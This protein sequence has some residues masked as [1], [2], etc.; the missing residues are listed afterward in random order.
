MN[1]T[2][3]NKSFIRVASIVLF[4][5]L[6]NLTRAQTLDQSC[7]SNGDAWNLN[8]GCN[9]GGWAG[10]LGQSF[11]AGATGNLHSIEL[12]TGSSNSAS[13]NYDFYV[14]SGN[15]V[16]GSLLYSVTGGALSTPSAASTNFTITLSSAVAIT[17]GQQYTFLLVYNSGSQTTIATN[18]SNSCYAGGTAYECS[19]GHSV[20]SASYLDLDFKTYVT[21]G[22]TLDQQNTSQANFNSVYFQTGGS[23]YTNLNG[24]SFTAGMSGTLSKIDLDIR[25]VQNSGGGYCVVEVYSGDGHGGSLLATSAPV[26]VNTSFQTYSFNLNCTVVSGQQYTWYMSSTTAGADIQNYASNSDVYA[27]GHAWTRDQDNSTAPTFADHSNSNDF[28]FKTYVGAASASS[29]ATLSAM[30]L[31]SGTLSPSFAS[32]TT[33][34]TASVT[35]ST[36]SI[37]VTPTRNEAH[38]TI[39]VR[40]NGGSYS[41]V[42]SGNASSALSLNFG[43]NTINVKV[44]A[45][46]G[47]TIVT[48]TTTVTRANYTAVSNGNWTSTSTWDGNEVPSS[49][50]DIIVDADLDINTNVTVHNLT[51]NSGRTLNHTNNTLSIQSGGTIACNGTG[52]FHST[53]VVDFL[54]SASKTGAGT[55]TFTYVYADAGNVDFGSS[56][57]IDGGYLRISQGASISNKP[58]YTNPIG[59]IYTGA[60]TITIGEEWPTGNANIAGVSIDAGTTLSFGSITSSRTAGTGN[61]DVFTI[62]GT[63]SLS[64]ASGGDLI[65]QHT[66]ANFNGTFNANGRKVTV[67]GGGNH[68]FQPNSNTNPIT[69][70]DLEVSG[71]P[72]C[73]FQFPVTITH[74]L[75]LTSGVMYIGNYD[76]TI[77]SGATLTGGSA[78]S[79]L[80]H[81]GSGKLVRK[82]IGNSATLFPLGI[83]WSSYTP[84]TITNGGNFDYAVRVLNTAPSGTGV[85]LPSKVL[86]RE[87]DITP[88]GAATNVD[89]TFQYNTGDGKTGGT[90][91]E[92]GSMNGIR[93]N[94]SSSSWSS[95]GTASA[96]GSN[97][98]TVSLTTPNFTNSNLYSV[99]NFYSSDATLSNMTLSVGTLSPSFASGTTSYTASVS[100][101]TS[102]ITVTPTHTNANA[103]IEARVNGGSYASVTSGSASSALSLNVGSNTID[104]RVTAE[105][106]TT[107]KTYTTTVCRVPTVSISST[108]GPLCYGDDASFTLTGTS[109][110]TV[111]YN[112]NGASNTT[113]VLTGGTSIITVTGATAN[114]TLN[115]VSI[116]DGTCSQSLSGNSTIIVNVLPS[117]T[118]NSNSVTSLTTQY[119]NGSTYYKG[120]AFQTDILNAINID[121]FDVNLR[122]GAGASRTVNVY[123]K[124]GGYSGFTS[125][126]S[127]WTLLGNY[128]VTSAG[129]NNATRIPLSSVLTL[130][131]GNYSFFFYENNEGVGFSASGS[132]GTISAQN[133]D[134]KIRVGTSIYHFFDNVLFASRNFN[135]TFYYSKSGV[136]NMT[137]TGGGSLCAGSPGQT[138]TLSGSEVG[139]NYQLVRNGSINVGS[140]KS[141]TG[142]AINWTSISTAGTYTV[143]ATNATTNCQVTLPTN[144]SIQYYAVP[145]ASISGS[146]TICQSLSSPNLTFTGSSGTA[147]YTFTYHINSGSDLTISTTSG[148]S[149][150]VSIPTDSAGTFKYYLTDVTDASVAACPA[151][152]YDSITAVILPKPLLVSNASPVTNTICEG[153]S[154]VITCTNAGSGVG[155]PSYT[156]LYSNNFNT[157]IGTGW[158]F[159]ATNPVTATPAI[160]SW[161]GASVLGNMGAQQAILNLTGIPSHD[162]I[163]VDFDLYIHDTW[164]GNNT[165]SGPDIFNM[166]VDGSSVVNTTFSNWSFN[167]YNEQA[168]PNNIPATNPN[169]TGAVATNLPTACNSAVSTLST[170]YH[171]TKTIA[172]TASSLTLLLEAVGIEVACNESWSIDNLVIQR[173]TPAPSS[174]ILWSTNQVASNITVSPIDTT[175]Y[176]ATLGT[177]TN[178]ITI[179]VNPT[180]RAN[181]S[182]DNAGQC[183]LTNNFNLTNTS[184]LAGPGGFTSAWTCTGSNTPTATSTDLTNLTY[185]TPGTKNTTLVVTSNYGN[186]SASSLSLASK[187]KQLDITDT[188]FVRASNSNPICLGSSVSLSATQN[189]VLSGQG[190]AVYTSYYT[191]NF[192]TSAD[193]ANWTFP[194]TV[195]VTGT[196]VVKSWG[197]RTVLGNMGA[198]QAILNLSGLP[199]HDK[200][201]VEF[202]LYIHDTWDGNNVESGPDIWNMKVDGSSVINTTFSNWWFTPYNTQAYPGNIPASNPNYTGSVETNLPTACNSQVSTLSTRYRI[203]KVVDH[204]A[205]SLALLLEAIGIEVACNESWSID[206]LSIQMGS[207]SGVVTNAGAVQWSNG[208]TSTNST[209]VVTPGLGNTTYTAAIGHCATDYTVTVVPV[210]TPAFTYSNSNCS[211][212]LSFTNTNIEASVSYAWN[213]G[214]ASAIYNGTTA[215]NHI[216]TNGTYTITLT[217]T[218]PSGCTRQT[219]RTVTIADQPTASFTSSTSTSCTNG[220]FFTSTSTI[221]SGNT[222]TYLWNFGDATTSTLENPTKTYASASSYNVSLTVTTGTTCTSTVSHSVN[223]PAGIA[224]AT[225][226]F[227]AAV[228]GT[229]GNKVTTTNLTTGTGNQYLWNFDDGST[230][231][232]FEPVH[233][234]LIGGSRTI[235]LTV[236]NAQGCTSSYNQQVSISANSGSTARIG[237]DFTIS[238]SDTQVLSTNKFN[239]A[240]VFT[241]MPNN[242]PP[243]YANGAPTWSFGDSTSSTNT[244]IYNKVYTATGNY[245][246]KIS[247]L[248]TNTG[249]YSEASRVV[250]VVPTPVYAAHQGINRDVNASVASATTGIEAASNTLAQFS[251]YPNPNNGNFKVMLNNVNVKNAEISIVDMLGREVYN[252]SYRL[253]GSSD[254]LEIT[255]LNVKS[256]SY[257]IIITSDGAV[258]GR[259]AFI[260]VAN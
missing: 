256:G 87:W 117:I 98:Y 186:C 141:G 76:L 89:L 71:V 94:T 77:N 217:A 211:K 216:Y 214:D 83:S 243:V 198:Q 25:A 42:T 91:S 199:A 6:V 208:S 49:G 38:A 136:V 156:G 220:V 35:S 197:G 139:V 47:S 132:T 85:V 149:V 17:S 212:T 184:S 142:N 95:F 45:E 224:A 237:V 177:C 160:K 230:S 206:S 164:D 187:T 181:F 118:Y 128:T 46:D 226:N 30:T 22:A 109:G 180:P 232:D 234:Y 18:N 129:I 202:D 96:S 146:T 75:K 189:G 245:T 204:S 108:N 183:I 246:V 125:S 12:K 190:P 3:Q 222:A 138:L 19:N 40:V 213:F 205:S 103:T 92:T 248:T 236:I 13:A 57:N 86:N 105:D 113:T 52:Y 158:T 104:V 143:V 100:N 135:G 145:S 185:S 203:S 24:Q 244:N 58:S 182:I 201:K 196:P 148:N 90:F 126:T 68:H 23:Q 209:I 242:N 215:P 93:Y 170:K 231:S 119:S 207:T 235:S 258:I 173:R 4:L 112:I 188:V 178:T 61:N 241:N 260:M 150:T 33:T 229:C 54:G 194:A 219:T 259:K 63:L 106:G 66:Y 257:N 88:S 101:S 55:A 39:Q 65:L 82:N 27:G 167:P 247:Q 200:I 14:Y 56:S 162:F 32:G 62:D 102:S 192:N 69:F 20:Q 29:D 221:G 151:S 251:L 172:H 161:N 228:V 227:T 59:L 153:T 154:T 60:G 159:P 163:T 53:S 64:S 84:L 152:Y 67:S 9:S 111:T 249:C 80:F 16:G 1:I 78:S 147:P 11:T 28:N 41:S 193:T 114:Q 36:S 238:P 120:I 2:L 21:S 72:Q 115:L 7:T 134:M 110:A 124:S 51:I 168:Y 34:Y 99:S 31:S 107:Q 121:S 43:A 174:N 26:L 10:Q 223:A 253:S 166:K 74:D 81:N 191:N 233:Y 169:F 171:I 50:S 218:L 130:S 250:T 239:F 240:P 15:G 97:P 157:S 137:L 252:N 176:T 79:Y 116:T 165:S 122:A 225:A 254:E 73:G 131:P 44:T 255:N 48:Y 5:F 195:P 127:G 175:T 140:H 155:S 8:S 37:T 123:Y 210:P 179:N 144:T 133:S 70:Y